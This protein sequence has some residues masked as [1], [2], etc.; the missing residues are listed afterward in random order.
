MVNDS[1]SLYS[2]SNANMNVYPPTS[3][4]SG[5]VIFA[6]YRPETKVEKKNLH[7]KISSKC[8]QIEKFS[9]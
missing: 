2:S 7:I 5:I 3:D 9:Y 4:D 1:N 8:F 6:R